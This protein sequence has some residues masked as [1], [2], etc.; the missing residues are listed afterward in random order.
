MSMP[1]FGKNEVLTQKTQ[2]IDL[3]SKQVTKLKELFDSLIKKQYSK[4]HTIKVTDD[5]L[6][7]SIVEKQGDYLSS[8]TI[9]RNGEITYTLETNGLGILLR[10]KKDLISTDITNQIWKVIKEKDIHF[11][12]SLIPEG[13][14][15]GLVVCPKRP[16]LLGQASF[17]WNFKE[18]PS[19]I[20]KVKKILIKN[21]LDEWTWD[22]YIKENIRPLQNPKSK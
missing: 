12:H 2:D 15:K 18:M 16:D 10:E 4:V 14:Y 8:V 3:I 21:K 19:H 9:L 20:Q 6:R 11:K 1:S 17:L 13:N 5:I 7:V 22:Q